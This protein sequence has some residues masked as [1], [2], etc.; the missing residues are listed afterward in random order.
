V[1]LAAGTKLGPYEVL[2]PAGAGGMGEVYRARDTR[3]ER[4]VAIKVLPQ[5]LSSNPDFRARF[6]REAKAISSLQHA[7]ICTLYDVGRDEASGIDFLVMEYL[8]GETLAERLKRGPLKLDELLKTGIE[9]SDALDKAH[10][11]GLVHRDLKPGNVMLTAGGAKL[12]DFGLAKG[13]ATGV[14]AASGSGLPPTFTAAPTLTS[15]ASPLTTAGSMVGTFQY[16]SPEQVEGREADARSDIF[17]LGA[18]LYEMATGKR[19]FPGKSALSVASAILEKEPEPIRDV[20]P[21][22][23]PALEHVV[24]TCLAKDAEE[25]WQSAADIARQLRWVKEGGAQ[26]AAPAAAGGR[27]RELAAWS[28]AGVLLLALAAGLLLRRDAAPALPLVQADILAP[29]KHSLSAANFALSPDG[30]KLVFTAQRGRGEGSLWLRHM[31]SGATQ[32]LRGTE[33]ATFPFWSPDSRHIG[34]FAG[35]HLKKLDSVG[36][37]VVTLADGLGSAR[38]G[39]WSPAGAI[40]FAPTPGSPLVQMP[41]TGGATTAVTALQEGEV[42]HRWPTLLPDGQTLIYYAPREGRTA[43]PAGRVAERGADPSGLY[44]LRLGADQ[45]VRL[46]AADSGAV[47][48]PAGYLLYMQ[49]ENLVAQPFDAGSLRFTGASVLVAQDVFYDPRVWTGAFSLSRTGKLVLR[50]HA[51]VRQSR[52]EWY[53]MATG[54][55]LQAVGE[56]LDQWSPNLSP[57][58]TRVALHHGRGEAQADVWLV[59]VARQ[60]RTR[61][62]HESGNDSMPIWTR[63][64]RHVTYSSIVGGTSAI[65][66]KPASG[67]GEPET[68]VTSDIPAPL[69]PGDWSPDGSKLVYMNFAGGRGP[70]LWLYD[71]AEKEPRPLLGTQFVEASP[72]ISPDGRYMVYVSE[73]AGQP[74]I[75]VVT[76]PAVEGRWRISTES[77]YQ[78][79]WSAD[80]KFIF[81]VDT[82][83]HLMRAAVRAG[84]QFA[85]ESPE[86]VMPLGVRLIAR[87]LPQY[88]ISP[89]GRRVLVNAGLEEDN[90]EGE[91]LTLI[92]N[93]TAKLNR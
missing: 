27:G 45:P 15:P 52:L 78:P 88:D 23:P 61:F 7:H 59:D 43:P 10:R 68:L 11:R 50:R 39:V 71:R 81:Y 77:G 75:Y 36:G 64:G 18:V 41:E 25:R 9:M 31:D 62:A 13:V 8:E 51:G 1:T 82:E 32:E 63:D 48:D 93:W 34:F 21:L 65:R 29:A 49:Q 86:P 24:V 80:G 30:S 12:L 54:K 83:G 74:E 76:F 67:I 4:D 56:A 84:E 5:R 58:G 16:M 19:A 91:T 38:G 85:V 87:T 2:A 44:A 22:T 20:Q 66:Q 57:D 70:R 79:R 33:G 89:D 72:R 42:S 6:E 92:M 17:A 47:Y 69:F 26:L 90:Q 40:I 35:L 46:G 60:V 37:T 53:D 14:A 28:L 73:D 3:L 55:R